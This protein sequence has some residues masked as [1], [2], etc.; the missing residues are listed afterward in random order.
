MFFMILSVAWSDSMMVS[1]QQMA[2]EIGGRLSGRGGRD[3]WD[4]NKDRWSPISYKCKR[5]FACTA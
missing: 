5:S 4:K 2:P 3:F 1:A